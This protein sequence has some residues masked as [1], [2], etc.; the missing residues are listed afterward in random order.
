MLAVVHASL[1]ERDLLPGEHPV[2]KG[3]TDSQVLVD[4][5]RRFGVEIVGSVAD[6]PSWQ[7]HTSDG[8]DKAAFAIDGR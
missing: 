4:S 3:Y 7:A 6:D 2:D 8:F 5:P 1:A